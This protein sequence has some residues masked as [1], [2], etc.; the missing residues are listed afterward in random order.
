MPGAVDWLS[1]KRRL[2]ARN[3]R[4]AVTKLSTTQLLL[5]CAQN[6]VVS[7]EEFQDIQR[8]C[9]GRG[10]RETRALVW[11]HEGEERRGDAAGGSSAPRESPPALPKAKAAKRARPDV[12]AR[13]KESKNVEFHVVKMAWRSF[14]KKPALALPLYGFINNCNQVMFEAQELANTHVLRSLQDSFPLNKLDQSFYYRCCN[15]V[16]V[17]SRGERV[18]VDD[19]VELDKSA[20]LFFSWKR[21]V[22]GLRHVPQSGMSRFFQ[23]MSQMMK[24]NASNL[25]LTTFRKRLYRHIRNVLGCTHKFAFEAF[26]FVASKPHKPKHGED[27]RKRFG[28]FVSGLRDSVVRAIGDAN[29]TDACLKDNPHKLVA[30]LRKLQLAK[31]G[32]TFSLL[33]Q[34]D[35]FTTSSIK[36]N[37]N[38]L[39]TLLVW[40]G[41]PDVPSEDAFNSAPSVWWR[42]LFRIEEV[43][44]ATKKFA[45][46]VVTDGKSVS[47][48]LKR[49]VP[50]MVD[51]RIEVCEGEGVRLDVQVTEHGRNADRTP[52]QALD[53]AKWLVG[54]DPGKRNL[55][56]AA[57]VPAFAGGFEASPMRL[58][59]RGCSAGEFYNDAK[60][61]EADLRTRK[62]RRKRHDIERVLADMPPRKYRTMFACRQRVMYVLE[63]WSVLREF[64]G[65]ARFANLK[66]KKF[67]HAKKKLDALCQSIVRL[68]DGSR[69]TSKRDV[70]VGYGDWGKGKGCAAGVKGVP[71]GPFRK[72]RHALERYATVYDVDEAYTSK[73]CSCCGMHTLRNMRNK[74]RDEERRKVHGV[75]HCWNSEC[76]RNTWDRDVNASR[77]ILEVLSAFLQ[78]RKRPIKFTSAGADPPEDRAREHAPRRPVV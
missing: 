35:G 4:I 20:A 68:G 43:E 37:N 77:N 58:E 63:H 39:R 55:F 72:L 67:V 25:F 40:A 42:S 78:G 74:F 27:G 75:L 33:P 51:V 21:Q 3:N 52:S 10:S 59:V 22:S 36:I 23:P 57:C 47:I 2:K 44:T 34:K 28:T 6:G 16:C 54:L 76:P 38:V 48:V 11:P 66:F 56:T 14:C 69:P 12:A 45:N 64:Y 61:K 65:A 30:V 26:L 15:A 49:P 62:W 41:T 70:V 50:R 19:D 9:S 7:R 29:L 32:K 18:P 53:D 46:E 60:F 71:C 1:L 31:R 17:D 5:Q 8:R 13:L 73:V 24:T